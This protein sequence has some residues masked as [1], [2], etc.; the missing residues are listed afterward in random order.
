GFRA[1][2][3]RLRHQPRVPDRP[4]RRG[5]CGVDRSALLRRRR[6][7]GPECAGGPDRGELRRLAR[8]AHVHLDRAGA[9]A[10]R[11]ADDPLRRAAAGDGRFRD[12]RPRPD[13]PDRRHRGGGAGPPRQV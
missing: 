9:A 11:R 4:A 3:T 10:A 1:D 12:H 2:R 6:Q 8:P 13:D 5:G 7:R